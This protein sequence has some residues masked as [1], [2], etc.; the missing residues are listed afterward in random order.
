MPSNTWSLVACTYDGSQICTFVFS[1][2]SGTA[3]Q[4]CSQVDSVSVAAT[5]N[6]VVIGGRYS[7][8]DGVYNRLYGSLDSAR[9]F[10]RALS[11]SEI[12]VGGGRTG[13]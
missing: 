12:C 10:D 13:C 8:S 7:T 3:V 11:A 2:G 4:A 9:M 1:G 6:G 5:S